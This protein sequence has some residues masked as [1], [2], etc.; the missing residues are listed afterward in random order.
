MLHLFVK[1]V[2]KLKKQ[3]KKKIKPFLRLLFKVKQQHLEQE[4]E[5]E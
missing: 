2:N 3:K 4:E 1:N 5:Q